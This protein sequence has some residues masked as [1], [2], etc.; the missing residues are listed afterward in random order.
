MF[1]EQRGHCCRPMEDGSY[2]IDRDPIYFRPILNYLRTN[3]V[4]IDHGVSCSAVLEEAKYFNLISMQLAMLKLYHQDYFVNADMTPEQVRYLFS[5]ESGVLKQELENDAVSPP[6]AVV[7]SS[8]K[9]AQPKQMRAEITRKELIQIIAAAGL[10]A[11]LR[12]SGVCFAYQGKYNT[13]FQNSKH[14]TIS[15]LM[16]PIHRSFQFRFGKLCD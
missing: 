15:L 7:A 10:E 2:F 1:D 3:N 9:Y 12:L 14:K 11:R 8:S 5:L 13:A 16:F 6:A 4:Y